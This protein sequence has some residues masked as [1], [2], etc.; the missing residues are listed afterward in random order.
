MSSIAPINGRLSHIFSPR[1]CIF[2]SALITAAGSLITASAPRLSVFLL[3]RAITGTGA[4]GIF[5]VS[6][7]LVV[8]LTTPKRRGLFN[9]ILN[10]GYTIGVAAGAVLAGAIEPALGWRAVFWLQAPLAVIAGAVLV[11]AI[12]HSVSANSAADHKASQGIPVLTKLGRIDYLG[13]ALLIT[14]VT[15][16]LYGLSTPQISV[17]PI[18][19]F[20][21]LSPLFLYREIYQAS[22]PIIPLS[23][24]SSRGALLSC[25]ATLCFMMSRWTVLFY[26]PIYATAIQGWQPS[27][28]GSLLVPTNTGFALGGL[29]PGF[30]HIR[31]GGSFWTS[32]LVVFAIFP[33]TL[34][35]L[36][37]ESKQDRPVYV[38]ILCVFC[39]GL[40]AGAALNYTLAHVLHLVTPDVR[41]IVTSLLATFRGF[42]GTFGSA[43]GGGIFVRVLQFSLE[44]GFHEHGVKGRGSLIR[45]LMGSPRGVQR[46]TGIERLVAVKGYEDALRALFLSGAGLACLA[47]FVQAGT[48]WTA[49][50]GD[51][52]PDADEEAEEEREYV[53][54]A[55]NALGAAPE[56]DEH[57]RADVYGHVDSH[58]NGY[59][60]ESSSSSL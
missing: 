1:Y 20:F 21:I 22:D 28:A 17:T 48:G 43:I 39:N 53:M 5:T 52:N 4:A 31:R 10:T 56:D 51:E 41:F 55:N 8:Q 29:I 2:T 3:G 6:I 44:H 24:L 32:C 30:F 16:L 59:D 36:A 54:G 9:G 49:P 11:L 50:G 47:W 13:A 58:T 19:L 26:T 7:I 60:A 35:A 37:L 40:C 38:Y 15:F 27:A 12:P 46:L 18:I 25:L 45:E 57:I 42:A 34:A 33:L 23:V 14:S